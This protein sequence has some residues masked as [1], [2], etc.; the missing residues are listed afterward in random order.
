MRSFVFLSQLQKSKHH[1]AYYN[2]MSPGGSHLGSPTVSSNNSD[3]TM[4]R[5]C[6]STSLACQ[7]QAQQQQGMYHVDTSYGD[8]RRYSPVQQTPVT[9]GV[10]YHNRYQPYV[11][12]PVTHPYPNV[13]PASTRFQ[14]LPNSPYS[15]PS[16]SPAPTTSAGYHQSVWPNVNS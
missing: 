5:S 9:G 8:E 11:R 2:T 13:A 12:P 1:G 15:Q 6:S 14:T 10:H 4:S 3:P 16:Y 7:V